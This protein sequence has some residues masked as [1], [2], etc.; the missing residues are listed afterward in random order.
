MKGVFSGEADLRAEPTTTEAEK[1]KL[2][3]AIKRLGA[4][5]QKN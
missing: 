3:E 2:G 4:K 5:R 1:C